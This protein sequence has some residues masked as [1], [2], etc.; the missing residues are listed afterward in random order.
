[1]ASI[2]KRSGKYQVR[3]RDPIGRHRS[4]TFS[5]KADAVKFAAA[6]TADLE[7]GT[8]TDPAQAKTPFGRFA[9][10]WL[11]SA[12]HL[13]PATRLNV[14]SI[15]RKHILGLFGDAP[16]G[17]IR[18]AHVREWLAHLTG[19]GLAAS[20]VHKV[21]RV[22]SKIMNVALNEGLIPR[23]PCQGIDLPKLTTHE[24]MRF[25]TGEQVQE[26]AEAHED[27]YRALIFTAAYSGCRWGELAALR[28][29]RLD[30]QN[31]TLDVFESLSEPNGQIVIGPTKTGARRT[32]V[33][34]GFLVT[35]L[36]KHIE[37]YPNE[38]GFIFTSSEG[39]PLRRNYYQRHFKPAVVRA[40]LDPKLRF[41]DLRHTCV[42]LLISDKGHP[43]TIQRHLGH[44]SFKVTSDRYGHLFPELKDALRE[45][46]EAI[47]QKAKRNLEERDTNPSSERSPP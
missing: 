34:P 10:E 11:T 17:A 28:V 36:E 12:T 26:L 42:A 23:S 8:W 32:V 40:G 22:F 7:R 35:M 47:Y 41:H 21:F 33:I 37:R 39:A 27:R 43:T 4:K 25:L 15:L 19:S 6:V 1:M 16:I 30:V 29:E 20:T 13:R 5:K 14:E 45:G 18:P 46:L 44:S 31:R 2:K 24:E 9:H 3:Y 38:Q